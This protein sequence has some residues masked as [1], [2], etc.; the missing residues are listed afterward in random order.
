ME[1][2]AIKIIFFYVFETIFLIIK[3]NDYNLKLEFSESE[4]I[5]INESEYSKC[6]DFLKHI[7][8][9]KVFIRC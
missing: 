6:F 2:K 1:T 8:D 5:I 9:T 4:L 3:E 7:I